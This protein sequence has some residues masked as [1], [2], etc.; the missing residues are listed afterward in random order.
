MSSFNRCSEGKRMLSAKLCAR[1]APRCTAPMIPSL[2]PA[3]SMKPCLTISHAKSVAILQLGES[4]ALRPDP[5][6]ATFRKCLNGAKIFAAERISL[7]ERLISLRSATLISS[8]AIFSAVAIISSISAEDFCVPQS[9]T[10]RLT[11]AS[12][13]GP[14]LQRLLL[15]LACTRSIASSGDAFT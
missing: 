7:A 13:G 4:S 14:T 15:A 11:R 12:N 8:R 5:K 1:P 9:R 10:S 2:P 3:I 6:T